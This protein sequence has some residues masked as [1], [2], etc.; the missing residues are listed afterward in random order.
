MVKPIAAL[1]ASGL[2]HSSVWLNSKI[3]RLHSQG[4]QRLAM[5]FPLTTLQCPIDFIVPLM[6]YVHGL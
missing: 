5:A 6:T 2:D 3:E 4:F 1:T